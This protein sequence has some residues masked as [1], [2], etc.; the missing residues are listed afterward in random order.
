MYL[1]TQ[2]RAETPATAS[3]PSVKGHE[4]PQT[5]PLSSTPWQQRVD[6]VLERLVGSR[7]CP[8]GT[9]DNFVDGEL[10]LQLGIPTE[11]LEMPLKARSLNG[12]RLTRVLHRT[13]QVPMIISGNHCEEVV[14]HL[15]DHPCPP[16]VLGHPWLS[17]HNPQ[18]DWTKEEIRSCLRSTVSCCTREP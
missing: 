6:A 1:I 13:F 5:T 11:P 12:L 2:F 7:R 16:L 10:M 9:E 4:A 8:S 15:I 3:P 17:Q 14:L 18:I